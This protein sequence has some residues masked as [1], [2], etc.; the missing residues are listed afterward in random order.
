M[1]LSA[2]DAKNG[3]TSLVIVGIGTIVDGSAKGTRGHAMA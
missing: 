2:F 1:N 3:A